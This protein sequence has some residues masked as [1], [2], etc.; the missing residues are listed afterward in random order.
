MFRQVCSPVG[1]IRKEMEVDFLEHKVFSCD[2]FLLWTNL[3]SWWSAVGARKGNES[4]IHDWT[5]TSRIFG[6]KTLI[7]PASNRSA[8]RAY[9]I[10]V[11]PIS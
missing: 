1:R 6:E 7:I 2:F 3:L 5:F 10:Y 9:L 4:R 8:G 11:G